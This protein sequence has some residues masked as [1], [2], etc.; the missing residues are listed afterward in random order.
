MDKALTFYN[1]NNLIVNNLKIQ[2]AQQNHVSFEKCVNVQASNL[3][4]IAPATNSN[5]DAIHITYTQ[6]IH[7]SNCVIVTPQKPPWVTLHSK[8]HLPYESIK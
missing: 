4:V 5:T 2:D 6:N 8:N 1:D 7:I 3:K